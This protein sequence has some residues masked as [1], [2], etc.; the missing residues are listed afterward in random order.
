MKNN[1]T[2]TNQKV[3][4]SR[5]LIFFTAAYFSLKCQL[6]YLKQ[7]ISCH[8]YAAILYDIYVLKLDEALDLT[9]IMEA[10]H[11]SDLRNNH[12]ILMKMK[13][14]KKMAFLCKLFEVPL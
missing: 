13:K 1:K 8:C 11:F 5:C 14:V 4:Y 7:H 12:T 9:V 2:K 3:F 6:Y 10:P